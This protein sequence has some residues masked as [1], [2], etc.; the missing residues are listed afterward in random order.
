M[1]E[2]ECAGA[3]EGNRPPVQSP[4]NQDEEVRVLWKSPGVGRLWLPP[5][6]G[7]H[8]VHCGRSAPGV[9]IC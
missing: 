5:E 7:G 8:L 3:G 9:G 6:H 2:E 4:V 1:S